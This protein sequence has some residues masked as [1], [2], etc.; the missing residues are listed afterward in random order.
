M[1]QETIKHII[2]WSARLVTLL[3]Y[4][5][6]CGML[7]GGLAL[8][9]LSLVLLV[10]ITNHGAPVVCLLCGAAFTGLGAISL[11]RQLRGQAIE[12]RQMLKA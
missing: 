10:F 8:M 5:I 2:R 12:M 4:I 9:G 7:L 3:G 6:T 11:I 1:N